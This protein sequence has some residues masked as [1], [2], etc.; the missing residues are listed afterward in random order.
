MSE[1]GNNIKVYVRV[2]PLSQMEAEVEGTC[3]CLDTSDDT[4]IKVTNF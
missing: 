4:T 1:R 3:R 2:R